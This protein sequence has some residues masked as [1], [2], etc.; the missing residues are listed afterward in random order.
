MSKLIELIKALI[1]HSLSQQDLDQA[2][3]CNSIDVV[4]LERRMRLVDVATRENARSLMF[5]TMMP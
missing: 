2:Y 4:D 1:P 5:G 3:L